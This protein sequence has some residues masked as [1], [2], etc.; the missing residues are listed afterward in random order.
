MDVS[1]DDG[2]EHG[3]ASRV[4]TSFAGRTCVRL[5]ADGLALETVAGLELADGSVEAEIAVEAGR[6]FH[7]VAWRLQDA[8]SYESFFVRPHQ[9]GKNDA[10][11]YTP[12]FNGMSAWQLHHGLGFWA[13]VAFPVGD[14]FTIRMVF[15]GD[16]AE[17]Y[18]ADLDRPALVTRLRRPP[19]AG[20]VGLLVAGAGLHLAGFAVDP[21]ARPR[22]APAP[23]PR[24]PHAIRRWLVSDPFGETERPDPAACAWTT[25]ES[26]PSGLVNLS[27]AHPIRDGRNT[28]YV[29]AAIRSARPRA[30][31]L[32]FG[33]SDRVE[34]RLNGRPL[35]RGDATYRSRDYRFLGSIGYWD[36]VPLALRADENDLV[37]VVSEDFGGWGVQARL[38]DL[39]GIELDG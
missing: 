27:R 8:D 30:A 28:V 3:T 2:W 22:V 13:P 5:D 7:G 15:A 19:A 17:A 18:V 1:L 9:V 35:Y 33:F 20:R 32:A 4:A 36:A 14:W 26:E 38:R 11:Q 24:D 31:E 21:G 37:L 12:V 34:V 10:I 23:D 39:D 6:S 16:R 25:L 29:R